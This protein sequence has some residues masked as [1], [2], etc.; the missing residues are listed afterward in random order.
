MFGYI[1][2]NKGFN[3]QLMLGFSSGL[4]RGLLACTIALLLAS[5]GGSSGSGAS[6]TVSPS[7]GSVAGGTLITLTGSALSGATSVTIGGVA[8]TGLSQ[9]STTQVSVVTP[10]GSLGAKDVVVTRQ[11]TQGGVTTTSTQTVTGGFT[12]V[13]AD[14]PSSSTLSTVAGT[15][16][17]AYGGDGGSASV[18]TLLG[19]RGGA[20]DS[21]GNFY[22]A[23]GSRIRVVAKKTGNRLGVAMTAGNIYT[24]A[25][26]GTAGFA[27]DTAAA[28]SAQVNAP[29]A[30]ALDSSGNLYIADTTN[31]RIRIVANVATTLFAVPMTVGSIYTIAGNGTGGFAGDGALAT[32]AQLNG[33]FG[34][35]MDSS[36][37]LY[38]ADTGNSR[39]R[40]VSQSGGT[41]LGVSTAQQNIYTL[42]GTGAT[43]VSANGTLGTAADLDAPVALAIDSSGNLFIGDKAD[44]SNT[45]FIQVLANTTGTL[46]GT[47]VTHNRVYTVAGKNAVGYSG[48]GAAAT[49]AAIDKPYSM[50]L[51]SAGNLFFADFLNHRIRAVAQSNLTRIGVAMST[52]NVYTVVGTGTAGFSG[53]GGSPT[54][55]SINSPNGVALDSSG[56]LFIADLSNNRIRTATR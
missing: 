55:A 30:V 11:S 10:A 42:A 53:D 27:G 8:G 20:V 25:G 32:G 35:A 16:T 54:T 38:I 50:A 1:E 39:V 33:P 34:L 51:D 45:P 4:I 22:F 3:M 31:H 43:A 56:N 40:V 41:I 7:S 23:D 9:I 6:F 21:D 36:F 46:L 52:G 47:A 15:G 28:T 26:N 14:W 17:A 49:A 2:K 18:A 48:D 19:P 13:A 5:C 12:Y 29:Q 37:N 24:V 44:I